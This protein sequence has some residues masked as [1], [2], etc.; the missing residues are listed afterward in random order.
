MRRSLLA[1]LLPVALLGCGDGSLDPLPLDITMEANRATTGPGQP[2]EFVV[3]ARGGNIV[4]L[5]I[6]YGDGA[7]DQRGASGARTARVTFEHSYVAVGTYQVRATV[8][9]AV[10]G[11]KD[12]NV[13]VRVQ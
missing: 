2:V 5:E 1:C 11:S 4:G 9:D 10:A 12:A 6:D 13:D 8:F 7:I 3:T